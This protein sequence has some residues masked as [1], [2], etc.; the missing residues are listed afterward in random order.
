MV[1]GHIVCTSKI[2][3]ICASKIE[4]ISSILLLMIASVFIQD[5]YLMLACATP[6]YLQI[7]Y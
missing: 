7:S 2:E 5:W 3:F 6:F 1:A 4:F